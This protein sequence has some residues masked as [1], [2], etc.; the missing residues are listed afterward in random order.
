[1]GI[2]GFEVAQCVISC[3]SCSAQAKERAVV[4]SHVV[5][6]FDDFGLRYLCPVGGCRVHGGEDRQIDLI[7]GFIF[8]S[9]AQAKKF[10]F[11]IKKLKLWA[12]R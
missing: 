5:E 3:I 7:D 12:A 2:G 8:C 1:M 9:S 4:G 10:F 6:K 11:K